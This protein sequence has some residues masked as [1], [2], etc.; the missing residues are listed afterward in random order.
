[1]FAKRARIRHGRKFRPMLQIDSR[2]I[3]V[4]DCDDQSTS[5]CTGTS[6]KTRY[7]EIEITK[8]ARELGL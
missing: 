5:I 6:G 7:F 8:T 4:R 1:M 2:L 3:P